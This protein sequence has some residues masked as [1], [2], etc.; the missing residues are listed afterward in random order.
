M[1]YTITKN[2]K[3]KEAL[4]TKTKTRKKCL[5]H[6]T[7]LTAVVAGTS[8]DSLLPQLKL[9]Q[10]EITSLKGLKR[11]VRKSEGAQIGR[12]VKSL[13]LHQQVV[14]ILIS[15]EGEIIDGHNVAQA[16]RQLG[17]K[18]VWCVVAGHLDEHQRELV[19]IALNRIG[20]CGEWDVEGLG[21]LLID[22]GALGFDLETTGFSLPELD[23][24]LTPPLGEPPGAAE[25]DQELPDL[26][27]CPTNLVGDLWRLGAHLVLCGDAT[28][29]ASYSTVLGTRQA[30]LIFTDCP[31]NIPI[32]GFV[33]GLGKVKHPDFK[34]GAGEWSDEEFATFC[35][36]FHQLGAQHLKDGSVFFS[37]IDWRSHDAIVAAGKH[38]GMRHI[39]TI[40]WNKGSGG[41]G[42]PYRSAHE[43][44]VVFVK[45]EKLAVNNVQLGKFGRD[46]TNV[47]N[48]PG[49]NRRG[50]SAAKALAYHPTPKPI[51]LVEDAI[52]D[53]TNAGALVLDMFLGSGTTVL[54]AERSGRVACGIELDPKYVDVAIHRWQDLTG[55]R[56]VHVETGLTFD[57]V[58]IA[59][60]AT[61]QGSAS[62]EQ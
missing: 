40:V 13:S 35:T 14:P 46:R 24:I 29:A 59:R 28:A 5:E 56:A 60:P 22:L 20:E 54:A 4:G 8:K 32:A 43:L 42:T 10:R 47:W 18:K 27:E 38:A 30:D 31:W 1:G 25:A 11:R 48:Y 7:S 39:N 16:L 12:I 44:V 49:A 51:E 52:K 23:I 9:E 61:S 58:R 2:A 55:E 6:Q 37:C 50:S 53:V 41:M 57:E 19:H 17:E 33:S 34:M 3:F 26:P 36:T 15:P 21:E 62:D 45:G